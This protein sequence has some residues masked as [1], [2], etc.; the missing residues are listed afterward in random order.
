MK[1]IVLTAMLLGL[2]TGVSFAQ[3]GRMPMS[4]NRGMT[5]IGPNVNPRTVGETPQL[6]R[7]NAVPMDPV[8]KRPT[9]STTT[10]PSVSGTTT[11]T[12]GNNGRVAPPDVHVGPNVGDRKLQP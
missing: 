5:Q 1:N 3:R 8:S 12:V 9:P 7:P 2:L 10:A 4:T 6:V 11:P